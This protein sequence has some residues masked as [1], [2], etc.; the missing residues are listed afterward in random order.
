MTRPTH[1]SPLPPVGTVKLNRAKEHINQLNAEF[2]KFLD[3][4]PY[5]FSVQYD[6]DRT[7]GN[8][9]VRVRKDA[10]ILRWSVLIGDAIHNLRSALDHM[11]CELV[12][13]GKSQITRHNQF[14]IHKTAH[15]YKSNKS[16]EIKGIC[17]RAEHIID[18]LQPYGDGN[19]SYWRLHQVDIYD[20]HR[21]FITAIDT[22]SLLVIKPS[23][24]WK[25]LIDT[26]TLTLYKIPHP[27]ID[28]TK[29]LT[30]PIP[31]EAREENF[32]PDSLEATWNIR[33]LSPPEVRGEFI[34][35]VF[36]EFENTV[37]KTLRML[38]RLL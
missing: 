38:S 2:G 30:F 7:L 18:R 19:K 1:Y 16:R 21:L 24:A 8:L 14:P 26:G 31:P 32:D 13:T 35:A 34:S 25:R 28:G 11:V 37:S 27:L 29:I 36:A 20:K 4:K 3:E 12:L 33:L 15:D 9:I 10:P 22:L 23:P 5:K 6:K 17:P